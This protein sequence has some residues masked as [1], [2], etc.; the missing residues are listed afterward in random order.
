MKIAK[1]KISNY[2][3]LKSFDLDVEENISLVIGKNNTGKTSLLSVLNKFLNPNTKS[4]KFSYNDLNTDFKKY[5]EKIVVSDEVTK[6]DWSDQ[7][8]QMKIYI[9]YNESDNLANISELI[10]IVDVNPDYYKIARGC[11][12]KKT[13][14]ATDILYYSDEDLSNW[15]VPNYI[16]EGLEWLAR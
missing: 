8:I 2:R 14:F 15:N 10:L 9:D 6:E 13:V 5:L 7:M 4:N 3:L 1:L 16:K 12:D 11:I